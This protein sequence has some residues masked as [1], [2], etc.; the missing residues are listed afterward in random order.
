MFEY[1]T[2][3]DP[4]WASALA[5]SALAVITFFTVI[6]NKKQLNFITRPRI[7][8]YE[9]KETLGPNKMENFVVIQN[10]GEY[11]VDVKL[12][13]A[14][15]PIEDTGSKDDILN[16]NMSYSELNENVKMNHARTDGDKWE[17]R[18]YHLHE[19]RSPVDKK[20]D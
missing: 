11:P 18:H 16:K 1:I 19:S 14:L 2:N 9:D 17:E 15:S 8:I 13:M 6:Q 20:R 12:Q 5:T 3:I 4:M 7:T 10:M